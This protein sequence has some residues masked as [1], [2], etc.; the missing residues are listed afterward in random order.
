[1]GICVDGAVGNFGILF[2][3]RSEVLTAVTVVFVFWGL[4]P[5]SLVVVQ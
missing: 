1:M 3:K 4:T 2:M 5:V